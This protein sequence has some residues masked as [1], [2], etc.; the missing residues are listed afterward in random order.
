MTLESG[1]FLNPV[2]REFYKEKKVV[3]E[4]RR[5]RTENSPRGRLF[6]EFLALAYKAHP[7][8]EPVVGNMSDI[9]TMTRQEAEGF[10]EQYYSPANLTIAVVG[11]VDADEVRSLAQIYGAAGR[12]SEAVQQ[13]Q[14]VLR[15]DP[16]HAEAGTH[17]S[18]LRLRMADD[19][20]GT[21]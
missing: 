6:E 8:G 15:L 16:D 7:Y 1:R 13:W 21:R 9:E 10:F 19:G 12:L 5:L 4:E 2:L 18:Q 14:A 20:R 3:M 11:D 17:L